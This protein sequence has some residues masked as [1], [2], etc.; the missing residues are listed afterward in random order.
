MDCYQPSSARRETEEN[1]P[2]QPVGTAR[3]GPKAGVICYDSND[4]LVCERD[5]KNMST[6][7]GTGPKMDFIVDFLFNVLAYKVGVF[8]LRLL[9]G[10]RFKGESGF[11]WGWALVVGGLVLYTPFVVFIALLIHYSGG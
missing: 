9:S 2:T 8:V 1:N 5:C 11:A 6:Q 3:S 7:G 10:G 4:E